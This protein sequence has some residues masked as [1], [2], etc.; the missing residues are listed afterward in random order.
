MISD[1]WLVDLPNALCIVSKSKKYFT[2]GHCGAVIELA[3]P[4]LA[5]PELVEGPTGRNARIELVEM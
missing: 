5:C 3:R 1:L 2:T 4:E